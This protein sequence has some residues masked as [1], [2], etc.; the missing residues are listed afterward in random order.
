M[1]GSLD[2]TNTMLAIIA[3][4]MVLQGLV[5]L[6]LGLAGWKIYRAATETLRELDE[7][8]IKPL[9]TKVE[10]ILDRVHALTDRVHQRAEKVEAAIEDTVARVNHTTTGVKSTVADSVHRV[11]DAVTSI[12]SL[13]VNALTTEGNGHRHQARV[14]GDTAAAAGTQG[15]VHYDDTRRVR[16]GGL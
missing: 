9:A 6:G 16:E 8:R 5:M 2:T 15:H 13:I 3:A 11:S 12:R 4:V 14:E 1:P 7:R 10:T